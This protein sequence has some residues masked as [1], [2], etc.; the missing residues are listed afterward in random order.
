MEHNANTYRLSTQ[1]EEGAALR[2]LTSYKASSTPHISDD[3]KAY[4][5]QLRT[6]LLEEA[7]TPALS[8]KDVT[9]LAGAAK[10]MLGAAHHV[11]E[12]RRRTASPSVL[13]AAQVIA[14][15]NKPLSAQ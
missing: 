1:A 9:F 5:Q 15:F 7:P 3:E 12:A 10:Y 14:N 2:A 11:A 6:R 4:A 8:D 13:E